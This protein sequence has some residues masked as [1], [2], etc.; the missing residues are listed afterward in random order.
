MMRELESRVALTGWYTTP[1]DR[2]QAER[3]AFRIG[4]RQQQNHVLNIS[5]AGDKGTNMP[6]GNLMPTNDTTPTNVADVSADDTTKAV[7]PKPPHKGFWFEYREI[8][9]TT[10]RVVKYPDGST[11]STLWDNGNRAHT[12][13]VYNK[14]RPP[15]LSDVEYDV[16]VAQWATKSERKTRLYTIQ[17]AFREYARERDSLVK[18]LSGYM[19]MFEP[20]RKRFN[21]IDMSSIRVSG[22]GSRYPQA[23]GLQSRFRYNREQVHSNIIRSYFAARYGQDQLNSV[24][25]ARR[26]MV[27]NSG[28]GSRDWLAVGAREAGH[29]FARMMKVDCSKLDE[30]TVAMLVEEVTVASG[31]LF[32]YANGGRW[33]VMRGKNK[34]RSDGISG[35]MSLMD[36]VIAM[37]NENSPLRKLS[38]CRQC[39]RFHREFTEVS[40]GTQYND[41]GRLVHTKKNICKACIAGRTCECSECKTIC[42]QGSVK[43]VCEGVPTEYRYDRANNFCLVCVHEKHTHNW[44]NGYESF[45]PEPRNMKNPDC[46]KRE[47]GTEIWKFLKSEVEKGKHYYAMPNNGIPAAAWQDILL[48]IRSSVGASASLMADRMRRDE[49]TARLEAGE[50]ID[51]ET[52]YIKWMEKKGGT[53]PKRIGSYLA[54]QCKAKLKEIDDT[55]GLTDDDRARLRDNTKASHTIKPETLARI[56]DIAREKC[57]KTTDYVMEVIQGKY[58]WRSGDFGDSGSCY[59]G[60]RESARYQLETQHNAFAVRFYQCDDEARKGKSLSSVGVGRCWIVVRDGVAC[61]FNAY[62]P[63]QLLTIARILAA[64]AGGT[65]KNIGCLSNEESYDGTLYINGEKGVGVTNGKTDI[66]E[67]IELGI[68]EIKLDNR[69]VFDQAEKEDRQEIARL[70]R[71]AEEEAKQKRLF[72]QPLHEFANS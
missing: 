12:N 29:V 66:S 26:N 8:D 45:M 22:Y 48:V 54:K 15:E 51:S 57:P 33:C 68:G 53:L 27:R 43:K 14:T 3:R 17:S 72:A 38:C 2:Y 10:I 40:C 28:L 64:K 46:G 7:P 59:W 49:A 23:K 11:D 20:E 36:E 1:S 69:S 55:Q 61:L 37:S 5:M 41:A 25:V 18:N 34:H 42:L 52:C 16:L 67:E 60:G 9:N 6:N 63:T 13:N 35:Y 30:A 50:Q 70:K 24:N 32:M 47:D 62:G 21:E 39:Y 71:V 56:G 58:D 19:A 31:K 44:S 65:Y 4:E